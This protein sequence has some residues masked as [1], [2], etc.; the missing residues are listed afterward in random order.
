MT[1]TQINSIISFRNQDLLAE[2][3]AQLHRIAESNSREARL[4]ADTANLVYK[5][6][7]TMRIATTIALIYL[8]ANLVMVC[9]PASY[10]L[11]KRNQ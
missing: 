10:F 4:M 2:N 7:R 1:Y 9:T 11:M 8:P 3:G 6:S 5:D